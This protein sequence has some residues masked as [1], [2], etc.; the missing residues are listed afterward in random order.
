M[1]SYLT[2]GEMAKIQNV[3]KQTLLF[4]DK[5]GLFSPSYIDQHNGYRYYS[6]S[7]IDEL[8]A[9]LLLKRIGIPL[10][11]I[12]KEME[13]YSTLSSIETLNKQIKKIDNQI[14]ELKKLKNQMLFRVNQV[15]NAL[16][17]PSGDIV[18]EEDGPFYIYTYPVKKPYT[19]D[20]VSIAT[21]ACISSAMRKGL[22]VHYQ[23]GAILPYRKIMEGKFLETTKVFLPTEETKNAEVTLLPKGMTLSIY[24]KGDYTTTG[25]SYEKLLQYSKER[26]LRIAS[27]SYEFALNDY[28]TTSNEKEYITRLMVYVDGV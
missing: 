17:H 19:L 16:L 20:K 22:S 8:D 9:I 27:D 28:F 13:N 21:K 26:G 24:H 10:K 23:T 15:E 2:A 25:K 14:K 1:E 6:A 5:I 7:Q 4:Y 3:S 11:E 12:R 18:L